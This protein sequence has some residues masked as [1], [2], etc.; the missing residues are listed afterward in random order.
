MQIKM[1]LKLTIIFRNKQIKPNS[2]NFTITKKEKKIKSIYKLNI[3][4]KNQQV[5]I[6]NV[7]IL[8]KV[9]SNEQSAEINHVEK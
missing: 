5:N 6:Q 2:T 8:F 3:N 9:N 1:N 4:Y 7:R